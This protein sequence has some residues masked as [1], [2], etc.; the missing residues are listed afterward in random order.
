MD[1]LRV[2]MKHTEEWEVTEKLCTTR[3]DYKV[4]STPSMTL[5]VEMTCHHLVAPHLK[6]GQGQVGLSVN[7]RHFAPTPI[8]R[9]VRADAELAAIDRR[10]L[11]FK[12]KVFDDVEQV[13]ESEH[14]RFVIDVDK[15]IER[16]KK[17]IEA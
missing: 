17:K 16:L 2:G 3:G 10:K 1:T 7:L 14:E 11:A 5:F 4:F 6:P 13:G 8:G 15:Y 12:V 9:K